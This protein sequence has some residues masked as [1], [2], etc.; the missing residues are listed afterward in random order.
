MIFA[1][2]WAIGK[3]VDLWPRTATGY[4]T[5]G[6][7][8]SYGALFVLQVAGLLWLFVSQARPLAEV[9]PVAAD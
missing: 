9:R 6:Y 8:W 5:D 7:T 2:Q 3:I 4:A 1:L